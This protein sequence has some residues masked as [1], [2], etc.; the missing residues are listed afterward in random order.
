MEYLGMINLLPDK[1]KKQIRAARTNIELVKY[2]SFLGFAVAFLALA[3]SVTYIFLESSKNA[4]EKST[5]SGQ[6]AT[7]SPLSV[8]G[9][10]EVIS[11][12]LSTAKSI[13]DKQV[14]YSDVIMGIATTLPTGV[15]LDRISLNDSTFGTPITLTA[16]ARSADSVTTIKENFDKSQQFTNYSL[17]SNAPDSTYSADYPIKISFSITI[18]K[19]LA[20]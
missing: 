19:G 6:S 10:A 17:V 3:C 14:V 13:L 2:L 15:I 20:Q 4:N 9:Q 5:D 12:N 11:T 18:N 1:I 16:Y 8:K 7:I